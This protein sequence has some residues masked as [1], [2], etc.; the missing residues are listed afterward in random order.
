MK[1]LLIVLTL[2]LSGLLFTS[3]DEREDIKQ[4]IARLKAQRDNL[5]DR[6]SELQS[7]KNSREAEVEQ[8]TKEVTTLN[9]Y[10]QGRTPK[11]VLKL[12]LKQSRISLSI[13]KHI[14]DSMNA[15]EFEMPVDKEFYDNVSIGSEVVD[16]FRVGSLLFNGSF[17][18]WKMTVVDKNIR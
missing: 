17:G 11:Y 2:T 4:D 18:D 3:C 8:L 6:N 15:I 1:K 10:K 14:K 9:I 7:I 13:S 12:K 5:I 16:E